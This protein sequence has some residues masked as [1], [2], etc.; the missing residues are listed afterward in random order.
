MM[1]IVMTMMMMMLMMM[2]APDDDDD[3]NDDD[4]VDDDDDGDA[5]DRISNITQLRIRSPVCRG[6][7][8]HVCVPTI[9]KQLL[10]FAR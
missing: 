10:V 3:D 2:L 9:R 8:R 6:I 5:V 1:M 4:D 7:V